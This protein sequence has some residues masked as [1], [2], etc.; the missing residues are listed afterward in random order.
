MWLQQAQCFE[1]EIGLESGLE[2]ELEFGFEFET[3]SMHYLL[4]NIDAD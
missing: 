1:F 4:Q 2:F 3:D